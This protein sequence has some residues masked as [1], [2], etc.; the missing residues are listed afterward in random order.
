MRLSDLT[1]LCTPATTSLA[2]NR[3]SYNFPINGIGLPGQNISNTD[4][5]DRIIDASSEG[6][7]STYVWGNPGGPILRERMEHGHQRANRDKY[8]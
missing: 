6:M 5:A 3:T 1:Q 8:T 4:I 2:Y 7:G